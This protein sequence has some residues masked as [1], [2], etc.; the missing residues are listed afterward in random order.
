MAGKIVDE[1]KAKSE[2]ALGRLTR[3]L[4]GMEASMD[5]AE[6]PGQWTTREVLA[7]LLGEP[8][9]DPVTTL[10]TFSERTFPTVEGA[11]GNVVMT[12]ERRTMTPKQFVDALQ[13]RRRSVLEYLE[14]LSDAELTGR[15]ARIPLFKQFMG[16]DEIPL[17][18]YAGA[19]LDLHWNDH[20]GQ[21]A[22]IRKTV[23]LPEVV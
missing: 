9:S 15:K 13:R 16:T 7:H 6:A 1:L 20:T 12:D 8:G 22:K 3:Q 23:G 18:V 11:A 5:R 19:L 10:K 17:Q 21:V 2:A 4:Q 14:G